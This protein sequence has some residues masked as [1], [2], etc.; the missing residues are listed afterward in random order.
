M[1]LKLTIA[2]DGTGLVG[3]Q[4]QLNGPSVQ[5]LLE[6]ALARLEGGPVVVAG[7]GRTDSGVHALGQVA[8]VTLHREIAA[9]AVVRAL[10]NHLP[11]SVRVLSAE[12]VGPDF[13]ARFSAHRKTYRYRI[14]NGDVLDPFERSY[15]WHIADRVLDVEAL[16]A[17]ARYLVGRH[18]FAA[19]Q[20]AGGAVETTIR[21]ISSS[22]VTAVDMPRGATLISYEV[23]GDGFLRHMV[24]S[25]V[26][27][28]VEVG[29]GRRPPSWMNDVLV[30]RKRSGAGRTAPAT[31][32]F[33]VSVEYRDT[34]L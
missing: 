29:R 20:G 1:L 5:A 33:L 26:G 23:S 34:D 31:G 15:V 32:L 25:I 18:D 2:Y 11:R 28:L 19:F 13:H 3:W 22:V 16:A 8:S 27:S 24:R 7:A 14:W 10:N 9:A 30:A 6:D 4:R 17:A 21:T 12:E